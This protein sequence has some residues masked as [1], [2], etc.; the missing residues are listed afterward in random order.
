MFSFDPSTSMTN[1]LMQG[2]FNP[3]RAQDSAVDGA[4]RRDEAYRAQSG[5]PAGAAMA[6]LQENLMNRLVEQIP[7]VEVA[8]LQ[9]RNP[10]DFSPEAIADRISSFVGRGLENARTQGRSDKEVQSLFDSAVRGMEQGLAEAKDILSGLKMLQ[11]GVAEQ[12]DETAQR[13]RDALAELDPS[14][15]RE[16]LEVSSGGSAALSMAE[17]YSSASSFE[18][19]VRT[20]DGDQITLKFGQSSE[21]SSSAAAYADSNG[22]RAA[23]FSMS[24]SEQV[25][26]SFSFEG[27]NLSQDEMTAMSDLVRDVG[28]MA[29]DFFGGDIQ[30]AFDQAGGL[31][32]D[33][34]QIAAFELNMSQSQQYTAAK[35]YR[36]TQQIEAPAEEQRPGMRLGQLMNEMRDRFSQSMLDFLDNPEEAGAG[37]MRGLV[38][39]DTRMRDAPPESR[40]RMQANLSDLLSNFSQPQVEQPANP[41]A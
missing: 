27:G 31:S 26:Y 25:G 41:A 20:Q 22:N 38:E 37:I 5:G 18:M 1:P 35:A 2:Q 4:Q 39:Q 36:Q 33:G 19:Q 16:Q 8:D 23:A 29:D 6:K 3:G 10:A 11:G 40:Q 14:R 30:K 9:K 7:G 13:T 34:S 28:Q 21:F 12:V 24:R 17:R 32:F 15:R